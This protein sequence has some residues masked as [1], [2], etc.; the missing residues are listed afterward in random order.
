[1]TITSRGRYALNAALYLA[2]KYDD[3]I[4]VSAREIAEKCRLS[5]GYIE[6]IFVILQKAGYCFSIRGLRG[7]YKLL[8]P[9]TEITVYEILETVEDTLRP[10]F[11]VVNNTCEFSN[12]CL[13]RPL[14][15]RIDKIL[16][17]RLGTLTFAQLASVLKRRFA[18]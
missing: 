7:G 4:P 12:A 13:S 6:Q 5:E 3:G 9:P 17:N 16:R 14:W 2:V 18:P 10:V 15:A 11:C 8:K 1:M